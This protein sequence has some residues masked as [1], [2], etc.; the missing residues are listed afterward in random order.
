MNK[1]FFGVLII[2]LCITAC[3]RQAEQTKDNNTE[4]HTVVPTFDA[5]TAYEFVAQQEYSW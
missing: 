5:D 3:N 4:Q 2:G 1:Y